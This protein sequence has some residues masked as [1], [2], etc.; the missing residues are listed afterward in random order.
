MPNPP[1][2]APLPE[3][4]AFEPWAVPV[5]DTGLRRSWNRLSNALLCALLPASIRHVRGI[6]KWKEIVGPAA[7]A[8]SLLDHYALMEEGQEG[9]VARLWRLGIPVDP[10]LKLWPRNFHSGRPANNWNWE[11]RWGQFP[12]DDI[13]ALGALW[14]ADAL[15]KGATSPSV[16]YLAESIS[17]LA[18]AGLA[19]A[20][21]YFLRM[22]ANPTTDSTAGILMERLL[23]APLDTDRFLSVVSVIVKSGHPISWKQPDGISARSWKEMEQWKASGLPVPTGQ[24]AIPSALIW[25]SDPALSS[26]YGFSGSTKESISNLKWW[27]ENGHLHSPEGTDSVATLLLEK[28]VSTVRPGSDSEYQDALTQWLEVLA[29]EGKLPP[30]PAQYP[31]WAHVF[32]SGIFPENFS[33]HLRELFFQEEGI[34]EL[35][36]ASGETLAQMAQALREHTSSSREELLMEFCDWVICHGKEASLDRALE[37]SGPPTSDL[38][39]PRRLRL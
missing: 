3:S 31:S 6:W 17:G 15:K 36:D 28:W 12:E 20:V 5:Q 30:C 14:Q 32:M 8:P 4:L 23:A 10:H 27:L 37:S 1:A 39:P 29:P 9:P 24:W 16:N 25:V 18:A 19:P 7:Y 11:N 26:G 35:K 33:P 2:P 34:W 22:G 21:D 38:D 13:R